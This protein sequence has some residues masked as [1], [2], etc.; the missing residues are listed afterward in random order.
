[1]CCSIRVQNTYS[2]MKECRNIKI[3]AGSQEGQ[4][5][6]GSKRQVY[7]NS[8]NGFLFSFCA[9]LTYHTSLISGVVCHCHSMG[10]SRG[11]DVDD[12]PNDPDQ[13]IW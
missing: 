2:D 8:C 3:R 4:G 5:G 12:K 1:M 7:D 6:G 13:G 10:L 9:L 11:S